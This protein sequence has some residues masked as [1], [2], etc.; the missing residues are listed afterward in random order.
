MGAIDM[1]DQS[2]PL[3]VGSDNWRQLINYM[4]ARRA[5]EYILFI[6]KPEGVAALRKFEAS[7]KDAG[8]IYGIEP[9]TQAW[10]SILSAF[11]SQPQRGGQ[12]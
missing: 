4:R 10:D 8:P 3:P 1:L 12:P 2:R 9:Y 5:E 11:S 6:V 7:V